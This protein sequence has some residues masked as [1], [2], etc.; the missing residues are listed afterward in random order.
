MI[1]VNHPDRGRH[2]LPEPVAMALKVLAIGYPNIDR[3]H[4]LMLMFLGL[5]RKTTEG[6]VITRDGMKAIVRETYDGS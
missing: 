6:F 3:R 5:A 2:E 4:G 1:A